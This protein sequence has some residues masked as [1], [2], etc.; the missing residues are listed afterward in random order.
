M[1]RAGPTALPGGSGSGATSV[2]RR[3]RRMRRKTR[4]VAPVRA[5][6]AAANAPV[7]AASPLTPGS[8]CPRVARRLASAV[9]ASGAIALMCSGYGGVCIAVPVGPSPGACHHASSGG[10]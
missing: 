10:R 7:A 9:L 1:L 8:G 2:S 4:A 5:L 6:H 3:C